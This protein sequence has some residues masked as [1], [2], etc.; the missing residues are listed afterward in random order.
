MWKETLSVK[1]S[2]NGHLKK[3][4]SNGT[5]FEKPEAGLLVYNKEVRSVERLIPRKLKNINSL[6]KSSGIQR[7]TFVA[8]E[9]STTMGI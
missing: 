3:L 5:K 1:K 8:L 7:L 6:K 4:S 2:C 9:Y